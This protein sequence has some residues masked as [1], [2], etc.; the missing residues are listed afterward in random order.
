MLYDDELIDERTRFSIY[1][2][3]TAHRFSAYM[4]G[5][6][7]SANYAWDRGYLELVQGLVAERDQAIE[8]KKLSMI[9]GKVGQLLILGIAGLS[10]AAISVLL[11]L[12]LWLKFLRKRAGGEL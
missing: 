9:R 3:S 5:F 6:H 12:F 11:G 2:E 7:N 8:T 10:V 4:G 1:R